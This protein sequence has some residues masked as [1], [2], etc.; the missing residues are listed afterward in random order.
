MIGRGRYHTKRKEAVRAFFMER[1]E[2]CFTAE[3]VYNHLGGCGME[4]GR[5]TVYRSI[6]R[7]CEEGMVRR[8]APP[9]T[10]GAAC[11]QYNPCSDPHL[12]LRCVSCGGIA[13]VDCE[14][15]SAFSRHIANQHGFALD[16][17]QT[18]LVGR[19]KQCDV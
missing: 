9:G 12:H 13:H 17:R 8:Y 7:L 4:V 5:T 14:E 15:A 19:C 3:E 10:G 6:S 18:V 16:E 2:R 11:Y 1:R